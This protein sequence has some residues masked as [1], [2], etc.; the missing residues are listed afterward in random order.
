MD[1][2]LSFRTQFISLVSGQRL[3]G[4]LT[5]G[6]SLQDPRLDDLLEGLNSSANS[7]NELGA[8]EIDRLFPELRW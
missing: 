1:E 6:P 2:Q 7:A 3:R 8:V 4:L 5:S